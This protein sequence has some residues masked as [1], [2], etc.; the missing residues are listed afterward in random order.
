[1]E[2]SPFDSQDPVK[3]VAGVVIATAEGRV[4]QI[5]SDDNDND[6]FALSVI[7]SELSALCQRIETGCLQYS[8][9]QVLNSSELLCKYCGRG[10]AECKTVRHQYFTK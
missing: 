2:D 7:R 4:I 1:M 9:P 5:E 6:D 10:A 3:T 8:S